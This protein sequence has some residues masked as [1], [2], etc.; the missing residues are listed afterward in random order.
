MNS[1]TKKAESKQPAKVTDT[2]NT[3]DTIDSHQ[4]PMNDAGTATTIPYDSNP[5]TI[6]ISGF[7]LLIK[8]AQSVVITIAVVGFASVMF[9]LLGQVVSTVVESASA[10]STQEQLNAGTCLDNDDCLEEISSNT[11]TNTVRT[12]NSNIDDEDAAAIVGIAAIFIGIFIVSL[13]VFLPLIVAFNAAYKGFIAA[14]TIAAIQ[15]RYIKFGEAFSEMGSRFGT[16]FLAEL[17][18]SLKILGGFIL[19]FVPGVRANLRYQALPY[20]IMWNKEID[21]NGAIA[22][23]KDLYKGHLMEMFGIQFFA[24]LIPIIGQAFAAGGTGLS[25]N[26]ITA[27]KQAN[28]ATPKAHWLNYLGLIV[29]GVV[30]ALVLILSIIVTLFALAL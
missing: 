28:I 15:N 26:Q 7:Q 21:A 30:L 16:L 12:E 22:T 23:T 11:A 14:G 4:Q 29:A 19:F 8:F 2:V 20:V 18:A 17:I 13:I 27:Y 10:Q 1:K 3:D 24:G 9:Q 6:S 25:L 5:F